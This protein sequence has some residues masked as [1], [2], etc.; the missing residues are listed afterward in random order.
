VGIGNRAA[1]I[2]E[3]VDEARDRSE[4]QVLGDVFCNRQVEMSH[5]AALVVG[6]GVLCVDVD[7][8]AG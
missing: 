8:K 6:V 3:L 1:V 4:S 2:L 7:A 5:R